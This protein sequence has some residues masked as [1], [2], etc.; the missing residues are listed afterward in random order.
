MND[1]EDLERTLRQSSLSP[2]RKGLV[3]GAI[4]GS[5]LTVGIQ[6]LVEIFA[7]GGESLAGWLLIWPWEANQALTRAGYQLFGLGWKVGGD[8][9]IPLAIFYVMVALNSA[10]LALVGGGIGCFV[11]RQQSKA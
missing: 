10:L 1:S 8:S 7:R 2:V 4:T 5:S 6:L 3:I 9:H 11:R